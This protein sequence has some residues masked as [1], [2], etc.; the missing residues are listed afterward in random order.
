[1]LTFFLIFL[2]IIM[3]LRLFAG[4][5]INLFFNDRRNDF[6]DEIDDNFQQKE[7][8]QI[9]IYKNPEEPKSKSKKDLLKDFGDYTDFEEV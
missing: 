2:L 7:E 9:K 8:G 3:L 1:M 6:C 5:F 4:S